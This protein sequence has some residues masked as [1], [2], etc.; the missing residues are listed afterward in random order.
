MFIAILL[1]LFISACKNGTD[2]NSDT[3]VRGSDGLVMSFL[4]NAPQERYVIGSAPEGIAI[5]IDV[6]N[7]GAHPDENAKPLGGIT[8]EKELF[9]TRG[10][11]SISGFDKNI[12]TM[13]K[14]YKDYKDFLD[15]DV[16]LPAAS[17]L[18]PRGGLSTVEFKGTINANNIIVNKYEPTILVT[19]CYPYFTTATPTVCIDPFPFDTRQEKVCNIGS[20]NVE[21]QGAPI[22][23]TKIDEEAS[24]GK[25]RFKITIENVGKGDVIWSNQ[26]SNLRALIYRCSPA[27]DQ[28]KPAV[29]DSKKILSRILDREDF[30]KVQLDEVSI[31]GID[32]LKDKKTCTPFADDKSNIVRL[33]DGKGFVICTLDTSSIKDFQSAFTTPISIKLR[34]VYRSTI[35]KKISI[36]KIDN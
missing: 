15:N 2:K 8:S 23:V 21:L 34:Y 14:G 28:P 13:Q 19:A 32:L 5:A 11:I 20:Q 29:D 24:S 9:T 10:R 16:Y 4:Q 7:K 18:N 1:L 12:I 17:P 6:W 25:I 36:Q 27:G 33:F 35:S 3:F 30:D 26:E 31:A 22:A